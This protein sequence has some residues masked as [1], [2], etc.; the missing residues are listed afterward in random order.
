M[1]RLSTRCVLMCTYQY[2]LFNRVSVRNYHSTYPTKTLVFFLLPCTGCGILLTIFSVISA[3]LN[4]YLFFV[5]S[6]VSCSLSESPLCCGLRT[7]EGGNSDIPASSSTTDLLQLSID[8]AFSYDATILEARIC[9][10]SCE[11]DELRW[12]WSCLVRSIP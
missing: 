1:S 7:K 12:S 3:N 11:E 2:K 6:L 4:T 10:I 9:R 8:N 5:A